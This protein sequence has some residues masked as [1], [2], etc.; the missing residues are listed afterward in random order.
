MTGITFSEKNSYL[1]QQIGENSTAESLD[2]PAFGEISTVV[3]IK[4][5]GIGEFSTI[6][7]SSSR[8]ILFNH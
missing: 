3:I 8:Q 6:L 5:I 1:V 7:K 4:Q 2:R